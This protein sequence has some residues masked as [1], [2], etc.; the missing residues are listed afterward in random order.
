MDAAPIS[1]ATTL[2]DWVECLSLERDAE[3]EECNAIAD[4]LP[5]RELEKRTDD[6]EKQEP[7]GERAGGRDIH[8]AAGTPQAKDQAPR[9]GTS[10][11]G[12][13]HL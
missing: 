10:S 4:S 7:D 8:H 11:A 13:S 6:I 12:A 1:A 3:R 2:D 5:V 9:D